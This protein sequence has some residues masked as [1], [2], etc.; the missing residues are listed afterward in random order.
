[1][2]LS[3]AAPLHSPP[4]PN[5]LQQNSRPPPL[6]PHTHPTPNPNPTAYADLKPL[7][8]QWEV[9]VAASP[10]AGAPFAPVVCAAPTGCPPPLSADAGSSLKITLTRVA[11]PLAAKAAAAN[12]THAAT[13]PH[14]KGALYTLTGDAPT[15]LKLRAC[16]AKPSTADRPWRKPAPIVDKDR[17]CPV[18][19]A[20]PMAL[21]PEQT[22]LGAPPLEFVF[23]LPKNT[24]TASFYASP[25]FEC[26]GKELCQ[27][28]STNNTLFWQTQAVQSRPASLIAAASVC[29]AIAPAALA[30]FFLKDHVF[31]RKK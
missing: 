1:M 26:A 13:A 29:S 22:A 8:G 6:S 27:Y 4:P 7:E 23:K 5:R 16:F 25:I 30:G 3:R 24:T 12:S 20:P 2:P 14:A 9:A 17:S 15:L 19:L 31:G 21:T 10:S 18:A 28:E 11:A